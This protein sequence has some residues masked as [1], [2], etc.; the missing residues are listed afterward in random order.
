MEIYN[1]TWKVYIHYFP[2]SKVYVG[3]TS[4]TAESRWKNGNGYSQKKLYEAIKIFGWNNIEH[5]IFASNLTMQEASNMEK[6]L[7]TKVFHSN[8]EEYGYN[9]AEGGYNSSFYNYRDI[10]NLWMAGNTTVQI[11][12][13]IGCSLPIISEALNVYKVPMHDRKAKG[14]LANSKEI[15]Q[16]NLNGDFIRSFY[17]ASEAA[18]QLKISQGN[19]SS[20]CRGKRKT[21]SGYIWKYAEEC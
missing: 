5:E 16:Y 19:I 18:R 1:G 10:Y 17:S 8:K 20:C 13:K 14:G 11:R 21:A 2:N 6:I 15:F 9:I 12:E 7:I 3:I 4:Q